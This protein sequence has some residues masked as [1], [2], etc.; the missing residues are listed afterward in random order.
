MYN[1]L[2]ED[3][4]LVNE[5]DIFFENIR[6]YDRSETESKIVYSVKK[7]RERFVFRICALGQPLDRSWASL[8]GS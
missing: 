4:N 5:K 8:D 6:K 7:E 1:Y 3:V 2:Q